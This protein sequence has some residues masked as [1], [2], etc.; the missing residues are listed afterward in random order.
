L[1]QRFE[2]IFDAGNKAE[3]GAIGTIANRDV[4]SRHDS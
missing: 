3:R 1:A 4:S 2:R